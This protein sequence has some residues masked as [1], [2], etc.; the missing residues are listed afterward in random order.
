MSNGFF[1]T[2]TYIYASITEQR[3]HIKVTTYYTVCLFSKMFASTVSGPMMKTGA[4]SF[5]RLRGHGVSVSRRTS[6]SSTRL[7]TMAYLDLDCLFATATHSCPEFNRKNSE[8]SS[9]FFSAD[10]VFDTR[11]EFHFR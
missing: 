3:S 2:Q 6:L 10:A 4:M 1:N 5:R 11:G 8:S 7:F 9:S